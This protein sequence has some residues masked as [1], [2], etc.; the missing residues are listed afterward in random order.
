MEI[1][2]MSY[3]YLG[4]AEQLRPEQIN[5][6]RRIITGAQKHFPVANL[7]RLCFEP[8]PLD[9]ETFEHL[10]IAL[11]GRI[12]Y[13]RKQKMVA[14][15]ILSRAELTVNQRSAACVALGQLVISRKSK[16]LD[17]LTLLPSKEVGISL[18]VMVGLLLIVAL[19]SLDGAI[20]LGVM[21]VYVAIYVLTFVEA[22]MRRDVA[23]PAQAAI[24]KMQVRESVDIL[25]GLW[26]GGY[27][28][29][30]ARSALDASFAALSEDDYGR[31][32]AATLPR[33]VLLLEWYT[34]SV[35]RKEWNVDRAMNLL[36]GIGMIG[37]KRAITA[38][39]RLI[40]RTNEPMATR[41]LA[42][43]V[44]AWLEERDRQE[45]M[46]SVLLRGS[47][48]NPTEGSLLRASY[49]T[50]EGHDPMLLV[51]PADSDIQP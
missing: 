47:S 5:K 46:K 8:Q 22:K 7:E 29:V 10:L 17:L 34:G 9:N 31:M 32:D 43:Q 51:R 4:P 38:V 26:M 41:E 14:S 37:D 49:G 21:S 44:V 45:E 18:G 12:Q 24:G 20:G 30:K 19:G 33:L 13:N 15:W 6:M 27:D 39:R 2:G 1:K 16:G 25:A 35:G 42:A 36:R 28:R 40:N 50:S 3:S 23:V 11:R 48:V